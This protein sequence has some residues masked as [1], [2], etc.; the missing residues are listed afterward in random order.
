MSRRPYS[1][2]AAPVAAVV[3]SNAIAE[4]P[5]STPRRPSRRH[6]SH[7]Q[8]SLMITSRLTCARR[9]RLKL[10]TAYHGR[11]AARGPPSE[12]ERSMLAPTPAVPLAHV[13]QQWLQILR[14]YLALQRAGDRHLVRHDRDR[15]GIPDIHDNC[16]DAINPW[17]DDFD[18]DGY[19]DVRDLDDD[20]DGTPDRLDPLP[21]NAAVPTSPLIAFT[22]IPW[23][24]GI[25]IDAFA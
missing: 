16:R 19:G 20:N 6:P 21:H 24:T 23:E 18:V 13:R 14:A 17:Q 8:Q 15:D 12:V 5:E 2:A 1:V 7:Y 25:L 4:A 10:V 22:S 3:H 9:A 11:H